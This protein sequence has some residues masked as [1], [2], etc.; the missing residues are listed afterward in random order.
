M[1]HAINSYLAIGEASV[2]NEIGLLIKFILAEELN[3]F[4]S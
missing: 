4:W 2:L 3:V 1:K